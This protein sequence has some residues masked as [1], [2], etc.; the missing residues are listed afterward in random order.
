[1]F[2]KFFKKKPV[3]D[4][5]L[6]CGR[7]YLKVNGY[8]VAMEGDVLRDIDL[9]I[10]MRELARKEYASSWD[11]VLES[12]FSRDQWT[13]KLIKFVCAEANGGKLP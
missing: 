10:K 5:G 13:G 3:V 7:I 4:W 11:D 12:Y 1:M 6:S 2:G 9:G 8:V